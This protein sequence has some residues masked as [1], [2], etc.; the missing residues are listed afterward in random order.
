[1]SIFSPLEHHMSGTSN[2][3]KK[4]D[5]AMLEY[6]RAYKAPHKRADYLLNFND[7]SYTPNVRS[8]PFWEN[9]LYL[10]SVPDFVLYK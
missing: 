2:H 3:G 10:N 9:P 7:K 1:M 6:L 8:Q 4:P 5:S